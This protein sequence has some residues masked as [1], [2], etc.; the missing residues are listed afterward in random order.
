MEGDGEAVGFVA[1]G[2]DDVEDG[3]VAVEFD[4]FVF[5]AV[6][7]DDLFAFGDGGDGL[8][9]DTEGFEGRGKRLD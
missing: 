2:L 1:D 4:G 8:V 7:V 9:G 5:L 6:D 3:V